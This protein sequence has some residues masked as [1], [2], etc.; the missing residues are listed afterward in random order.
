MASD[1]VW[2][3][4]RLDVQIFVTITTDPATVQSLNP[5]SAP[6]IHSFDGPDPVALRSPIAQ[7][8]TDQPGYRIVL[9]C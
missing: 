6:S 1:Y 2:F 5:G 7:P 9:V 4:Y 8:D 3:V